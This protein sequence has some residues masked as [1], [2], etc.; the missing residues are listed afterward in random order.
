MNS[1]QK[2][3]SVEGV[4][5]HAQLMQTAASI[6]DLQRDSGMIPWFVNGHCDPWNHVETAMALDVMGM[7]E[8]AH[9]AYEWLRKNQKS[10]GSWSNYFNF[11][12]TLK[13]PKLD[14]NVCAYIGTGLWHHWLCTGDF[15]ALKRFWPMLE[16]AMTWVLSMRLADGTVLWAREESAK[17]WS[18]ALLTGCA[19]IRHAL[20]S[21]AKIADLIKSPRPEWSQAA[22]TI[23]AMIAEHPEV[24]E[25]KT[26]WAM[27]WY[28]PVLSGSL[29]GAA[30][31][32][33]LEENFDTF[34]MHDHGVR[35][36]SDEPW[37]TASETAECSMAFAAIGDVDTAQLL[38][39]STSHHRTAD[40]S[41]LTGL[42][43][44]GK[45]VFPAEE[46]SA[47]TGAAII[48]ASDSLYSISPASRIFR[49][50]EEL[51]G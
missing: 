31:K 16:R 3:L 13:D 47:Y 8:N 30:A 21:A 46:T 18:Y 29:V 33:R 40:G 24:F 37:V 23:D 32:S 49:Y 4:L 42:V 19:S 35:C 36:V 11:D 15:A 7:H 44:P 28:Y 51:D 10:D 5:T 43:Y 45:I 50:D 25:P 34:V 20:V 41:Y 2:T 38:L 48:L 9:R 39:N 26:R 17:P 12:G 14:S 1:L 6:A 22:A 27:D